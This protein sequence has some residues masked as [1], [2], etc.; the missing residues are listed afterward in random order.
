MSKRKYISRKTYKEII[1]EKTEGVLETVTDMVLLMVFSGLEFSRRPTMGAHDRAWEWLDIL[2]YQT[3]KRAAWNL[4]QRGLVKSEDKKLVITEIGLKK[5]E[6]VIPVSSQNLDRKEGE[7]YLIIYDIANEASVCRNRFRRFLLSNKIVKVQ[8]SVYL[9]PFD[10]G[11]LIN[12]FVK[13]QNLIGQVLVTK[14]GKDSVFGDEE[15]GPFL[16][17]IYKLDDLEKEYEEFVNTYSSKPTDVVNLTTAFTFIYNRDPNLPAEFL[18]GNWAGY[19]AK[20][21]YQNHLNRLIGRL[22]K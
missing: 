17:R 6:R 8:E 16:R 12:T 18:P 1:K 21:L 13:E 20:S 2:N 5:L 14:M 22:T 15:T 3:I 9:S 4:K 10:P 11:K 7:I 19:K